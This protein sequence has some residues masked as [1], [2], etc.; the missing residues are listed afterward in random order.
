MKGA[1]PPALQRR[2]CG[3][4]RLGNEGRDRG[5]SAADPHKCALGTN[6][7]SQVWWCRAPSYGLRGNKVESLEMTV[8]SARDP[9]A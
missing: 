1:A 4:G 7:Q 2:A 6:A 5:L 8:G 9:D 3:G